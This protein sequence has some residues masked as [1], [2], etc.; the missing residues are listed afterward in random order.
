MQLQLI[1]LLKGQEVLPA[2]YLTVQSV[3]DICLVFAVPLNT[4]CSI[5]GNPLYTFWE[6]VK[7]FWEYIYTGT[8]PYEKVTDILWNSRLRKD[9]KQL[10]PMGQTFGVEVFHSLVN[11]FAPKMYHF[12]YSG[13]KSR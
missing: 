10:S 9:I 11:Q 13:M 7:Y 4:N 1:S 8:E 3:S 2:E 12:G 6:T 5:Y